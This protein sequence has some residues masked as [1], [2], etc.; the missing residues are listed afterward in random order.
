MD[1]GDTGPSS[2]EVKKFKV[3]LCYIK[4]KAS[5]DYMTSCLKKNI[6]LIKN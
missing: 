4:S 6:I 2:Q 5:M 1:Y 3:I